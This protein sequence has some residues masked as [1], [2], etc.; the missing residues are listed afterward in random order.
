M[1]YDAKF[2]DSLGHVLATLSDLTGNGAI[3]QD[4]QSAFQMRHDRL[5]AFCA[6]CLEGADTG[7]YCRHAMRSAAMA[8]FASGEPYFY[9]CWAGLLFTAVA[10]APRHKCC[11]V[12][13]LGGF[14][15]SGE[16]AVLHDS[17]AHH[18]AA[19]AE[20]M[21]GRLL[22]AADSI[23]P[24]S[25]GAFRGLGHLL[26][27]TTCSHGLN[28]SD[29]VQEQNRRYCQQR[30]IAEALQDARQAGAGPSPSV[31]SGLPGVP[32]DIYPL[33]TYLQQNDREQARRFVSEYLA[34]M[35]MASNWDLRR[36]KAH[37][38]LLLAA[39]TSEAILQGESWAAATSRELQQMVRLES[40]NN[41]E[42]ACALI[43]D[44]VLERFARARP[45]LTDPPAL[46][47]RVLNW[48][49]RHY[50]ENVTLDKASRAVGA[51]PS[52]IVQHLRRETHKSFHR[53]LIEIRVAEAKKMLACTQ[54]EISR[55]ADICGFSDQSH[56]TRVFKAHINLTPGHF[57]RLLRLPNMNHPR[58]R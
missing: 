58:E 24:I 53:H 28:S 12:L 49:R 16:H 45:V 46:S 34:R 13:E 32:A 30:E 8:S 19:L 31:S 52:S 3:Y 18:L 54:M 55:I 42:T 27:E 47:E 39:L 23:R 5:C 36:L 1:E 33:L 25:M 20:P 26:M 51:A 48:L 6:T 15:A 22:R 9:H 40:A 57:R 44:I 37:L 35:L 43:A 2:R 21:R 4:M 29:F 17:L 41:T 11:G 7:S 38:R 14:F 56:F 10:L 50:A